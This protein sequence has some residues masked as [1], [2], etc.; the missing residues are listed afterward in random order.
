MEL[1]TKSE[2]SVELNIDIE[3]SFME[4]VDVESNL[5]EVDE[6]NVDV[7][8][9]TEMMDVDEEEEQTNLV[10][11]DIQGFR[12]QKPTFITKEFCLVS[13]DDVYHAI[14]KSPHRFGKLLG[15]F[16]NQA[17]YNTRYIHGLTWE[18]GDVHL[19]DFLQTAYMKTLGKL[20]VVKGDQKVKWLKYLF[21]NCGEIDCV[22]MEDWGYC[23]SVH[24]NK[25]M[26]EICDYHNS[27]YSSKWRCAK[28]NALKLQEIVKNYELDVKYF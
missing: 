19:I 5:M 1:E 23:K 21:R 4:F 16:K 11:V 18:C 6:E 3:P 12:S 14:I 24:V 17:N 22:N 27:N 8:G 15:H 28:E 2:S 20:I 7:C 26:H 9:I 25:K 10:F 13:G